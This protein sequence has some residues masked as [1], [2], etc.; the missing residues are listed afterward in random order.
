VS[1]AWL[2]PSALGA[3]PPA[4][5]PSKIMPSRRASILHRLDRARRS[6]AA[7]PLAELAG[8]LRDTLAAKWGA[9]PLAYAPAF[10]RGA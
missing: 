9:L 4:Q 5:H 8:R 3:D 2:L 7:A 10:E 6:A 1:T